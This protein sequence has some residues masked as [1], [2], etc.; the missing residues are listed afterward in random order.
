MGDFVNEGLAMALGPRVPGGSLR[1]NVDMGSLTWAL[2]MP[3]R[4]M[5]R[6]AESSCASANLCEKPVGGS[7][8]TVAIALGV[9]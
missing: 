9:W 7:T 4:V 8:M 6:A 5:G 2:N 1:R 3:S